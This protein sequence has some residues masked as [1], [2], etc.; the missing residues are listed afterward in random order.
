M[1]TIQNNTNY[2][3]TK[4]LLTIHSEDRDI[5]QW[6]NSNTFEIFS[7]VEYKNVVSLRLNDIEIPQSFYVFST[8]NQN[9]KLSFKVIPI[10]TLGTGLNPTTFAN[11][12]FVT[13]M[14]LLNMN[15]ISITITNGQYSV[16]Q[17]EIELTGLL[18]NAMSNFIGQPYD[19]FQV[20]YNPISMK[21]NILNDLDNF[22]FDFTVQE[23]YE[24]CEIS[25]YEHYANWGLGSYLGFN[26]KLYTSSLLNTIP[27]WLQPTYTANPFYFLETDNVL[28]IQGDSHVYMELNL[29]NSM[30]EINPYPEHINWSVNAKYNGKHNSAFAKIPLYYYPRKY[31]EEIMSNIFFSD[32]PLE[33]I[34]RFKLKLRYHDGRLLELN[35]HPYTCTIEITMLKPDS[36]KPC[37]RVNSSNYNL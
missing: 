27:F 33:R 22:V 19:H 34:Q 6:P 37:I 10:H 7:P 11:W 15:L 25:Y 1:N 3:V 12:N 32:P 8:L 20:K 24:N 5:K 29:C 16:E 26:K 30:D 36:I 28:N 9:T 13:G 4:K 2:V 31:T 23:L 21:L 14:N 18:N 17:L 35:D